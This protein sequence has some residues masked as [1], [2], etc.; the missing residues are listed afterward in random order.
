MNGPTGAH[1]PNTHGVI[2]A[3]RDDPLTLGVEVQRNDLGGVPQQGVQALSC[4]HVPQPR[5][6]VHGAGRYHGA[7]GIERQAH[8]LSRV[9][10]I[11]MV[12]LSR[13]RTPQFAGLI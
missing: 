5:S 9:A 13:L 10:S 8:Y 6:V 4:L 7:V 12:Q 3:A 11:G 1:V 2:E